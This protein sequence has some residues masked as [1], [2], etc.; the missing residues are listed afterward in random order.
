[1]SCIL[2]VIWRNKVVIINIILGGSFERIYIIIEV[3][4]GEIGGGYS[5]WIWSFKK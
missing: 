1:M 4:L 2:K 5:I 3:I